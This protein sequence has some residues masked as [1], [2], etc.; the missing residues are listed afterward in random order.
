LDAV[1]DKIFS[2]LILLS[3]PVLFSKAFNQEE[4]AITKRFGA[5][6]VSVVSA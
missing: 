5:I 2:N 4:I 3:S 6:I 1:L